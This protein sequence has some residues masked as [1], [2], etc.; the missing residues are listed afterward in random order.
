M[1]FG[2]RRRHERRKETA[3]EFFIFFGFDLMGF[4]FYQNTDFGASFYNSDFDIKQQRR[5]LT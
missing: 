2:R 1:V 5:L 3:H 4:P